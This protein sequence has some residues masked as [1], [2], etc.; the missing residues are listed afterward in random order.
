MKIKESKL[1]KV[2]T[3]LLVY[4]TFYVLAEDILEATKK[5]KEI[6]D[7]YS[8]DKVVG[9]VSVMDIPVLSLEEQ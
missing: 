1:F 9:T 2:Y 4:P 6:T 5:A 8:N 7:Y 3:T